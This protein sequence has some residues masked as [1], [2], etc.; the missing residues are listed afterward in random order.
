[1]P[2]IRLK[3]LTLADETLI[4]EPLRGD[5]GVVRA[6]KKYDRHGFGKVIA[7]EGNILL[8]TIGK[9]YKTKVVNPEV[10]DLVI[11]DDSDAIE[12]SLDLGDGNLIKEVELIQAEAVYGIDSINEKTPEK[13][14][15]R[16]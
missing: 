5:S 1:M 7:S 8:K 4:V 12:F 16:K 10:G 13:K 9:S 15:R 3:T 11:Y 6:E 2:A 14:R